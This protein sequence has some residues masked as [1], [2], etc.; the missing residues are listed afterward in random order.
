MASPDPCTS[1][2]SISGSSLTFLSASLLIMSVRDTA[3]TGARVFSRRRRSR[4]SVI[5]RA[6]ASF[7]T[8]AKA[9]PGSGAPSRPRISTGSEGPASLSCSSRSLIRART[10]P[11]DEPATTMSPRFRVPRLTSTVATGPRPLSSLASMTIP[12]AVRSG[13]AFRSSTSACSRMASIRLSRPALVLAETSTTCVSPPSASTTI[14]CCSSSLM[15]R[16][17]FAPGLS[18]LLMATMIGVWAA[19]AWLMA[20]IVCG[21]TPSSAATTSTTISVTLAP[22]ARMAEKAAWPGV[23]RKVTFSP[24]GR[25]T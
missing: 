13:L 20:S 25:R 9:S 5:S 3:P 4:Y 23:S 8:T 7:S 14:S 10:R 22:R 2:L 6:R 1:D 16:S 18:I 12:S 24:A 21:M 15:M 19:R 11:N 17:G